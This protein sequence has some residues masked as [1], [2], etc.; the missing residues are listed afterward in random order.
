MM[1]VL[2]ASLPILFT[3]VMMVSFNWSAKRVMPIAWGIALV[4]AAFVWRVPAQWLAGETIAGALNAVNILIIVFGAILL[5]NTLKN[6]G[7]IKAINRTFHG[8]SPDPRV[9]AI[10]VAFLFVSFIE[11]AAGFGT[12]AALAGPLLVSLGFPPLA[13]VI[14]ALI[15]DS[16]SVSFGAVGTPIIG[17]VARVLDSAAVRESLTTAGSTWEGF[18]HQVGVWSAIPHAI[19]GTFLP[20]II[21]MVMSR[22]F[23]KERSFKGAFEVAPFAIFAGLAFTVPYLLIAVFIGPELPSLL[24]ALVAIAVVVPAARSGFL[25]P[26]TT[27]EFPER[28]GWAAAWVGTVDVDSREDGEATMSGFKAWLPYILVALLLVVTRIPQLGLRGLITSPGVTISWNRILGTDLAY[29]LQLLYLPGTI[30][31]ILVALLTIPMHK[32]SGGAVKETWTGSLKQIVPASIALVFAL[33]MVN[34]MRFSGNNASGHPDMLR[35]LSV[36]AAGAFSSV[37][38]LVAPFVGILGAFMTGSNTVSNILFSAFQ[39][40]V[41][42]AAEI[43]RTVVVGLQVIGG[44]VGN[45][46]CV[47]N[48]V[49]ASTVVGVLGSE[50]RIIRTNMVPAALYALGVGVVGAIAIA[51]LPGLF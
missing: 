20:L 31:F 47:H 29:R 27:W 32:M 46:I 11:G 5:M 50:G 3:I 16:T 45:M 38:T 13:A 34:V 24:G 26:K 1:L 17:G 28:S 4:L 15:G 33:G 7:A 8:I 49:A 40:E 37:W 48:V 36:A 39:Y 6:S 41:A 51:V 9:Q 12:P 21:V 2:L 14:L 22:L 42:A 18:V 10:I 25:A 44:A 23:G 19:V 35:V 43:S 30:P